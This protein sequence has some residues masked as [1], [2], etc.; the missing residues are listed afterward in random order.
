MKFLIDNPIAS[1]LRQAG[2]DARHVR[3]YGMQAS[4]DIEIL[5][6]LLKKISQLFRQIQI[7]ELCWL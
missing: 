6:M 5:N 7:L 2:F 1:G 4:E 3:D